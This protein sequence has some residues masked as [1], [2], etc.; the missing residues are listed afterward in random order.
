MRWLDGIIHSM[1]VSLSKIWEIV[2]D[3]E[4]WRAAV[5]EV[6]KSDRTEWLNNNNMDYRLPWWLSS[7][8]FAFQCRRFKNW[9]FHSWVGKNPLSR[10][11]QPIQY[12]FLGNPMDRG[13]WRTTVHTVRHE[14]WVSHESVQSHTW[15]S[16]KS[17]TWLSD[18]TI[19]VTTPTIVWQLFS[20]LNRLMIFLPNSLGSS[21]T[22]G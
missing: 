14:S 9:G 18:W 22:D 5:H 19:H 11:W 7:K 21:L 17:Q 13:S 1:D 15:V 8:E 4:A 20:F 10:K 6:A 16:P 12:S 3:R 2:K